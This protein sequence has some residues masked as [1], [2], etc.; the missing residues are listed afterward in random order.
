MDVDQYHRVFPELVQK[1][2]TVKTERSVL[3]DHNYEKFFHAVRTAD[4]DKWDPEGQVVPS[5]F[6]PSLPRVFLRE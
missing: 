6:K 5:A 3:E 2:Y 1:L 4:T